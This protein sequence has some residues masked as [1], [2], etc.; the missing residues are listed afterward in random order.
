MRRH[1][2]LTLTCLACGI[3]LATVAFSHGH[4]GIAVTNAAGDVGY[5]D[6]TFPANPDYDEFAPTGEKPQSKLWF[7]GGR[8]WA[9]M[10]HSDSKFYIF[11]L[12]LNTQT[13]VKT[14]TVLD[15][16]VQTQADCLWDGTKLYV[17]SGAGSKGGGTGGEPSGANLDAKLYRYSYN[18][19]NPPATAYTLDPSFPVIVR[20]G[21][22][23][24]IVIDKDTTGQLWITYTQS[25][26]VWI[27]RSTTNDTTWGAPF[28]PPAVPGHPDSSSVGQDD[29]SSLIAF[30]G[31]I[32]MLW[33]NQSDENFYFTYH[34]DAD[35]DTTWQSGVAWELPKVADDHI[36]LKSLQTTPGGDVFAAVKTS[37]GSGSSPR[38]V[39][40]HRKPNGSW[41]PPAVVWTNSFSHTRPVLMVDNVRHRIYVF[42][43]TTTTGGIIA[44][45]QSN[46]YTTGPVSFPSAQV[47]FIE[48]AGLDSLNNPTSTK[49]NID[50]SNGMTNIVI[51]ASDEFARSYAHNVLP[52]DGPLPPTNTP[53]ASS[54]TPTRTPTNTPTS[55]PTNT[56]TSTPT[57]TPTNTPTTISTSTPTNTPTSTPT[58]MPTSTP[59]STPTNKPTNTPTRVATPQ[60][61]PSIKLHLPLIRR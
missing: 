37:L 51:L 13:W 39:V 60:S 8:W 28:N 44:Y 1:L 55:T 54:S 10:L 52:L 57:N 4:G 32:G 2:N 25:N 26:K 7:N 43:T 38:I 40:L 31:K 56:P 15:D 46:D 36:N 49:Q 41:D 58:N 20:S 3:I 35:P 33:S 42:A 34:N 6:Q 18:P 11:Y 19:A 53:G 17:V 23:E 22:A 14:D 48:I 16:R 29:I 9:S 59:T 21:G 50:S 27:N 61:S 12:D 5:L 30:D 24:T 45:K 47:T